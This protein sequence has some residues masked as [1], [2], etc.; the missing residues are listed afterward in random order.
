MSDRIRTDSFIWALCCCG[1]LPIIGFI[2]GIIIAIPVTILSIFGF[3]G[4]AI[5]LLPHDIFFTY[6][7]LIKTSIIGINLKIL[8]FLL[9]P[10]ALV[11]WPI[12][13]LFSSCFIGFG[14]G[15]YGPMVKTFDSAYNLFFGGIKETFVDIW[16][17]IKRFWDFNYNSF[18]T[19]LLELE[20]REVDEPFD[21]KIL[22]LILSLI[23]AC[24]GSI[25][26]V[27]VLSVMW[28]IKLIPT[29]Y[30][31]YKGLIESLCD[32]PVKI[33]FIYSLFFILAFCCVPALG[34]ATILMY[35]SCGIYGGIRCAIEGYQYNF[36]RGLICIWDSI[37]EI[38]KISNEYIFNIKGSCFPDCSETYKVKKT[39]KSKVTQSESTEKINEAQESLEEII[40]E[41]Q[42]KEG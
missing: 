24:Y 16:K 5:T 35:V 19:Y 12:L 37:Y 34:V 39:K 17:C 10:I 30:R 14:Y 27:I 3:T 32:M 33:L 7:V 26:G 2:K 31:L 40:T 38:D 42:E 8:A 36:L 20:E 18:F 29:I 11:S 21:I 6:R 22:Q 25:V 28:L 4:S 23:L 9:L 1:C 15:L 13:V 41:N